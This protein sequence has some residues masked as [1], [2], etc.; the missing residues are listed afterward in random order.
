MRGV[1]LVAAALVVCAG[2]AGAQQPVG[3]RPPL[4]VT[5]DEAI[6]LALRN[7]PGLDR[8]RSN[9]Q[10]AENN[11]LNTYGDFLPSVS[12]GYGYSNASTGRL[13]PTGQAF[14]TTSYTLQLGASY[15]LFTGF[16][17]FAD[18]KAAQLAVRSREAD[19][20]GSEYQ[21]IFD[22]KSRYYSAIAT[23]ELVAVEEDRVRRQENQ[24]EFVRQQL[25]L[26][27]ATRSDLLRSQVDLNNA[28]L[29]LLRAQNAARTATYDLAVVVGVERRVEPVPESTLEL[30]P[31]PFE[32]AELIQMALGS[33]PALVSAETAAEAAEAGVGSAKSAYLPSLRFSGGWAWAA[34]DFPPSNRSWS[35]SLQGSYPIF[36]GFQRETSVYNAQSQADIS[37]A[38]EREV[39]LQLLRDVANAYDEVQVALA[40]IDLAENSV[41]LSREDLRVVSERYRLG[42]ATILDLQTAQ[43]AVSEAEV[44]LIEERFTYPVG[45]A[46]IEALIGQTLMQ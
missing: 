35:L 28:K 18:A 19:Y 3:E 45:I 37:L 29:G 26:G 8:S 44:R 38:Q 15:D 36:N 11:R 17:R 32:R 43:I 14:A 16:R 25:D 7:N 1:A 10:I 21:T 2:E 33:A 6:R 9:L 39:E 42:L 34:S 4:Q 23:R 22:V 13:D 20:R 40:S 41:E 27:R 5:L 24:L 12:L 31:F 30:L 46:A